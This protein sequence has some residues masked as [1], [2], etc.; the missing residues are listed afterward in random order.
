MGA[1]QHVFPAD[2]RVKMKNITIALPEIYV[3]NI[4]V[5]TDFELFPSRSEAIRTAV[6]RFLAKE[7]KVTEMIKSF[8]EKMSL[9]E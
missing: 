2:K 4:K 5:L 9:G 7:T 8:K 6:R 3:E 1:S